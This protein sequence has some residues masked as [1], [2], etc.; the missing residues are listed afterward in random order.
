MR[1]IKVTGKSQ[2]KVKPDMTRITIFLEGICKEYGETLCKSA[3]DTDNL[4]EIFSKFGFEREELKTISFN[5]DTEYE[6]S[7]EYGSYKKSFIGY[8]FR[9]TIKVEFES[10]NERLGKIMYALANCL[11]KTKF[12]ISYT[13]KEPEAVKNELLSKAIRNAKEKAEVLTSASGV[14]LKDI[15]NIEYSWGKID[16]EFMSISSAYLYEEE[17]KYNMKNNSDSYDIDIEPDNINVSD[18]VT[19]IW[20]IM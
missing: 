16:F 13:V 6:S 2:M 20:E 14:S 1:T 7:G 3:Q 19:I 4:R 5:V 17:N 10:D 8:K 18:T 12:R 9:H 15:Q 11:M